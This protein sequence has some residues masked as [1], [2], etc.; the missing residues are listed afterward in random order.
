MGLE[1]P[2]LCTHRHHQASPEPALRHPSGIRS[3]GGSAQGTMK[4]PPAPAGG[5]SWTDQ[6]V[7]A[8]DSGT[9]PA[10]R[11]GRA[12]LRNSE[13]RG[14]PGSLRGRG[15]CPHHAPHTQKR[16]EALGP[17]GCLSEPQPAGKPPDTAPGPEPTL[18]PAARPWP[19]PRPPCLGHTPATLPA[20]PSPSNLRCQPARPS[21]HTR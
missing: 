3:G 5:T 6:S 2:A 11:A 8:A 20:T 10:A 19:Q 9:S 17:R 12:F 14:C 16:G 7:R 13:P 15:W 1:L 18:P 4:A 21:T